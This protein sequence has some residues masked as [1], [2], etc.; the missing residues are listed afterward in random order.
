MSIN[1]TEKALKQLDRIFEYIAA[2]SE[3]YAYRTI[4]KIIARTDSII[5]HPQIGR[6]VPEYERGDIREV[7]VY[8]YR[9]IYQVKG[10]E[11]LILS[12]IHGAHLLPDEIE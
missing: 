7:F 1:W 10:E 2:D 12:V 3:L 6:S 9:I 11:I 4:D 8:S 5:E